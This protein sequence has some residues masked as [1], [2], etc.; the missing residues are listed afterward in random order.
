MIDAA[1]LGPIEEILEALLRWLHG[2]VGIPW[3]WSIVALTMLVRIALVPLTVRQIHSMQRLQAHMP[4]MKAIQARHKGGDRQKMNQEMMA[5]YKENKINPASSCLPILAQI[6]IFISL[7]YVLRDF[8]DEIL[9]DFPRADLSWLNVVPD[10]TAS[11]NSHWSG[12]LLLVIYAASQ[13]LSTLLMSTTM[14]RTQRTIM[15]VLPLAFLFIVLNFPAG[16]VLYWVTTNL[17]TMGQG[18]VTR[19]LAPK[20]PKPEKRSSRTPPRAAPADADAADGDGA[21][22]REAPEART[23]EQRAQQVRK[24]KRKKKKGARR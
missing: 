14:D 10:I 23:A 22:P 11:A 8:K 2:S 5:F 18:L 13:T 20:P 3:A 9:P 19:R 17:W 4:E 21:K 24:V 16:L 7:F 6:P 15:L 1:I 12:Y